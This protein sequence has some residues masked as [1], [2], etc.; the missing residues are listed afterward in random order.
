MYQVCKLD[1]DV[2][3][4]VWSPWV[5]TTEERM[6]LTQIAY[7]SSAGSRRATNIKVIYQHNAKSRYLKECLHPV[8]NKR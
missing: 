3:E 2:V 6:L 4:R 8:E 7:D 1:S 5:L